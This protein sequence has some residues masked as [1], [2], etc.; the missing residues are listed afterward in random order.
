MTEKVKTNGERLNETLDIIIENTKKP[1]VRLLATRM[2]DDEF[3]VD[4]LSL[5]TNICYI[6][7]SILSALNCQVLLMILSDGQ[8]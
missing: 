8:E 7:P 4:T 1:N 5:I 3:C 6:Q 2:K